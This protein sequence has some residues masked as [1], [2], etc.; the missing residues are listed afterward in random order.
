MGNLSPFT[1]TTAVNHLRNKAT[2]SPAATHYLHLYSDTGLTTPLTAGNAS[3]YVAASNTNDTTTWP[4]PSSRGV[5]NGVAFNFPAPSGTWPQVYGWKLTDSATEGAGNVLAQHVMVSP[6]SPTVA[7]GPVSAGVGSITVSAATNVA[8]GGF[9]DAVVHG[10][11]GLIFG[12]TAYAPLA[13]D[14]GS[15]WAGDPA[16][17]GAQAGSR[18]AITQ[19]TAWNA[20]SGGQAVTGASVALA[21]QATGTYWAEHD[22]AA[23]GNLLFTATRPATVGATGT[24]LAGQVQ[25]TIT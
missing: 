7:T 14:Y 25:T 22:A 20:A 16:G 23:A 1:R 11:L 3:G 24:I 2:Y 17:A 10:I 13:T 19:A 8:V 12:G 21:Q 18:V 5:S 4:A 15:H 6:L 9:T